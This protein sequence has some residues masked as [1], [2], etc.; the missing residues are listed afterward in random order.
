M[1]P[2]GRGNRTIISDI[3][4]CKNQGKFFTCAMCKV[5]DEV[6]FYQISALETLINYMVDGH[7]KT[8]YI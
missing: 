8:E 3:S 7:I 5:S 4:Q 2:R 6:L 1:D